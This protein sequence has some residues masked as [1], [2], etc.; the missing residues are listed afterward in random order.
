MKAQIV[1][2]HWTDGNAI[3]LLQNGGDFFPA[4]C[5]AIDAARLSV[6]LETYIFLLDRTG[7]QVLECL[8]S[9]ARRG[10]KVRVV[11]D[12][13]GSAG[14]AEAI[15]LRITQAGG[16]C[17]IFRP[18]PR[19]LGHLAFSR[20]RL[21]RLHRK[22][23]VVDAELAFVGGI[24]IVDDYDDLDP[25]DDIPAPRFDFAVAVQG[26]LVPHILYAQDLLWVRLNWARLRRHPGDWHRMRL[27]KPVHA[28]AS[29]AGK[30][31]A[32]LLLRDN[33]RFR[34][35]FEQAYLYGIQ[36]ARRDILIANAYFFPGHQF[37]KGLMQAAARGVRVRLLLQGK[38][39]YRMQY[40]ATRAL[41]DR[42][43]R[44]GIEIYEYMP[45]YLHA[46][47]A[48]IDNMATVGSS[49]LDPFSLL[50]AREANVVVDDQP[51]AWDL[52]E[53][54][55]RAIALGGQFIRPLDYQRRGWLR[56]CVDVAAYTMLRIGVALTGRAGR[57]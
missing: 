3:R 33:L 19:W 14:T 52:Q 30:L 25:G 45:G 49:N 4:L 24:N 21:R 9:A 42:L 7:R 31:R 51:F 47:V 50:L 12:G 54:L 18:E 8:E 15:R 40:F 27:F 29:P 41:Y 22:V 53:R 1:R 13:F 36:H 37:R 6:H 38:P 11:L 46:K 23:A 55:E 10:V 43:L 28:D 34:Q 16:Q 48:V 56:R 26:P 35:T 5:E 17:R 32:A 20:S 57:Y 44:G 39:E 2:L